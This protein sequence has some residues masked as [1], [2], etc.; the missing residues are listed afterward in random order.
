MWWFL[1]IF[2]LVPQSSPEV[3][4]IPNTDVGSQFELELLKNSIGTSKNVFISP[5]SVKVSLAML[6]AAASGVTA[7][8]IYRKLQLPY[9]RRNEILY[10]LIREL[11][12]NHPNSLLEFQNI[13]FVSDK[14]RLNQQY[15]RVVEN[16][17]RA[18][19]RRLNYYDRENAALVINTFVKNATRGLISSILSADEIDPQTKVILTNA[20]YF[21]ATWQT[22]FDKKWTKSACF[23]TATGPQ[24]CVLTPLM[25]LIETFDYLET[26]NSQIV[27]LNYAGDTRAMLI[28]V[29]KLHNGLTLALRDVE[30]Y[31]SFSH[32][33]AHMNKTDVEVLL[34]R[35]EIDYNV[36]LV[37]V[38]EKMGIREIFSTSPNLNN[39]FEGNQLA[40]VDSL[41]HKAKI[42]VNEEGTKASAVS[43]VSVIPLMGS[44]T[45]K[46]RADHPFAFFI[47]NTHSN[48]ILFEGILNEPQTSSHQRTKTGNIYN[49]PADA[50]QNR[51]PIQQTREN[52]G[53]LYNLAP[54]P[55]F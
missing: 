39:L 38:L 7:E 10:N 13:L 17:F 22:I 31:R 16:D 45:P 27:R 49:L 28:V 47:F 52:Q 3:F 44:S 18:L 4:T 24:D 21:K 23:H 37:R 20:L 14:E 9:S 32:L 46:V 12:E 53:D 29:P 25:L 8:Q 34:P 11:N 43:L 2:A 19:L 35:F 15:Q 55:R 26:A 1:L 30:S 33:L 51:L 6:A 42:E 41:I 54:A 5:S 36:D 40:K 50:I 48:T